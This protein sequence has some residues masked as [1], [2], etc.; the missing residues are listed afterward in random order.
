MVW[1]SAIGCLAIGI[2]IG[3]LVAGRAKAAPAKLSDLDDQIEELQDSHTRYQE[4]VSSHL[5]MTAEVV[6]QM[7][8]SYGDVYQHLATGA[9]ELCS[10]EVA[11]NLPPPS[12]DR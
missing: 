10:G 7:T 2:V 5:S 12:S 8:D 6:Q 1:L 9:Q 3:F 4:E 11:D